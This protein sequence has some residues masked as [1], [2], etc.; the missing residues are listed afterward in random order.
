MGFPTA[1]NHI[2]AQACTLSQVASP[3]QWT[4][5]N[6]GCLWTSMV[7]GFR[8][9]TERPPAPSPV[10]PGPRGLGV[11]DSCLDATATRYLL[12]PCSNTLAFNVSRDKACH[13]GWHATL[14]TPSLGP[15]TAFAS[16]FGVL[17]RNRP[18]DRDRDAGWLGGPESSLSG[19][20]CDEQRW[21][22][23]TNGQA[24]A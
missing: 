7:M 4:W 8:P 16:M 19:G 24:L 23:H 11:L 18:S 6:L 12:P 21:L 22:D 20:V 13:C 10:V 5:V 1:A 15:N 9:D 17:R 14:P 2:P 3:E